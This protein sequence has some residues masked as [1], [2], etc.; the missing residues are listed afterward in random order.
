MDASNKFWISMFKLQ[1]GFVFNP[2]PEPRELYF[3]AGKF[4]IIYFD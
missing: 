4:Y 2:K 1:I 3:Y